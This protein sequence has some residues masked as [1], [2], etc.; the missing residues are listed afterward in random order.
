MSLFVGI[1]GD[2]GAG[3]DTLAAMLSARHL[4]D[5]GSGLTDVRKITGARRW[6]TH[7][8][9]V[10]LAFA[11]SLKETALRLYDLTPM[12]LWGPS[13]LRNV[14]DKRYPIVHPDSHRVATVEGQLTCLD[15]GLT[16]LE[17]RSRPCVTYLTPRKILQK[18]GTEVAR[19]VWKDTWLRALLRRAE[20]L[21]EPR[22]VRASDAHT[23]A[24]SWVVDQADV[25]V[26][27]DV[28]FLNE[29]QSI[30]AADGL[31]VRIRRTAQST[32]TAAEQAHESEVEKHDPSV[33]GLVTHEVSNDGTLEDLYKKAQSI[34]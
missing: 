8:R 32:L 6:P 16:Y 15:C 24:A 31:L 23:F 4:V 12:S 19:E 27:S 20:G 29:M 30:R 18:L 21:F 25:V 26:I 10:Q 2:A 13:E 5:L 11:D 14:P 28:R 17:A 1:I 3:K 34:L 9:A 33:D 22:T 7:P